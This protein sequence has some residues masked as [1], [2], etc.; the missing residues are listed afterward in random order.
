MGQK[1]GIGTSDFE[2]F[3][4]GNF[5]FIDKSL[6]IKEVIE[7]HFKIILLPRPRRFGKT[8][9][10]SM[11]YYF[12]EKTDTPNYDIFKGLL[13]EKEEAFKKHLG[14]YPVIFLTFKDAKEKNFKQAFINIKNLISKEYSRHSYILESNMLNEIKK[15]EFVAIAEKK[16]QLGDYTYA[17]IN[18]SEYLFKYHNQKAVILIDEYDTPIHAA[19]ENGYYDDMVNFFRNFLGAGL[20]DNKYLFKGVLTGILRIARESIFS[21]LNNIGVYSSLRSEYSDYFGF[22][23]QE[24]KAVLRDF[25]VIEKF[26][27]VKKWYDGYFAAD[28]TIYNPWSIVSFVASQDKEF[29]P[30]WVNTGSIGILKELIRKSPQGVKDELYDLLK[31]IP[32]EKILNE[33]IVFDELTTDD[34]A[35]FSFL[36]FAGYLKAFDC[37]KKEDDNDYCKFLIPNSEVKIIFTDLIKGLLREKFENQKLNIMLKALTDGDIELFEEIFGDFVVETLSYF[38]TAGKNVEKVYQAFLLGLLVNLSP[39]YEVNSNKEAGYGRYDISLIPQDI[40]K[41]A[42]I[43]ELKTIRRNE[44]K[45]IA[46]EKAINQINEKQYEKEAL[47]RGIKDIVKLAVVFENKRVW[48]R[49]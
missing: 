11:L 47:K 49:T 27:D 48:I 37:C 32:I 4:E 14:K 7:D 34:T 23:E 21:G 8:L 13:I 9:N 33:N 31:D 29:R 44:T 40:S 30:Y 16:A 46:L 3:R 38:D 36:Y 43:M 17:L 35:L 25:D 28:K 20:K 45:D 6:F 1:I 24:V 15:K 26:N 5:Y 10:L 22:L 19:Y 39:N 2:E 42:I 12:F 18:L 41:K